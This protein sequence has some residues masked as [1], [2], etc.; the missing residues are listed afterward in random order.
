M[1]ERQPGRDD[2]QT[3]QNLPGKPDPARVEPVP[4]RDPPAP[5]EQ[6]LFN[7]GPDRREGSYAEGGS[8]QEGNFTEREASP[9]GSRGSFDDAGGY[10]GTELLGGKHADEAAQ[11]ARKASDDK[12]GSD[13]SVEE[14]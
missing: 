5:D 4:E 2:R 1:T 13:E 6:A 7:T 8:N 14:G 12:T 11:R 3:R 9:H 10:G